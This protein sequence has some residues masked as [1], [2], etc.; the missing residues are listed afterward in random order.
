IFDIKLM[1]VFGILGIIMS[2]LKMPGAPFLLGIILGNMADENLRR[3]LLLTDADLS[4]FFTRPISIFFI[5]VIIYLIF[6][7]TPVYARLQNKRDV[8]RESARLAKAE[9]KKAAEKAEKEAEATENK[10]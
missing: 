7:Q 4:I 1:F 9:A 8:R 2:F 6:T 3:A 5:L 10:D